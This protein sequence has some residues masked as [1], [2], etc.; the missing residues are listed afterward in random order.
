MEACHLTNPMLAQGKEEITI[1]ER[2]TAK[3]HTNL[4]RLAQAGTVQAAC[5]LGVPAKRCGACS[6]LKPPAASLWL[7]QPCED[8]GTITGS[9]LLD[10][11]SLFM[12]SIT[13]CTTAS[14]EH[15]NGKT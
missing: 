1:I 13:L 8:I 3:L 11:I 15:R 14:G 6:L 4:K 5:F 9:P 10:E 7:I 2:L 12:R